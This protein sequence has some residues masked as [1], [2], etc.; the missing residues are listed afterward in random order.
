MAGGHQIEKGRYGLAM[1][2]FL[3]FDKSLQI[4]GNLTPS[5]AFKGFLR[6]QPRKIW[7]AAL[8]GPAQPTNKIQVLIFFGRLSNIS[9]NLL[10]AFAFV[11]TEMIDE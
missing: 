11:Q 10:G 3:R 1:L 2:N 5:F 9:K 4:V 7:E 6:R 8:S